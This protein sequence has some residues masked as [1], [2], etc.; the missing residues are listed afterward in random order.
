MEELSEPGVAVAGEG[1]SPEIIKEVTDFGL[2][3]DDQRDSAHVDYRPEQGGHHSHLQRVY[4]NPEE[5]KGH[6]RQ[7]DVHRGGALDPA[8]EEI[9]DCRDH[10]DVEDID[11][12][13]M[14][15]TYIEKQ[16]VHSPQI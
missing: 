2:E 4:Q 11:Q 14:Q 12:R 9:Y 15:K 1:G 6:N 5:K 7:G 10:Q 16:I 13:H 8:E 3:D